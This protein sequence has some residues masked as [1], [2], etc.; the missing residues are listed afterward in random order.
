MRRG[1]RNSLSTLA[2][3]ASEANAGIRLVSAPHSSLI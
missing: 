2:G 1:T 3:D